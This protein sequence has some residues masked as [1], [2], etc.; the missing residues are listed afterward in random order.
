M[1]L[2]VSFRISHESPHYAR[3][4]DALVKGTRYWQY[5]TIRTSEALEDEFGPLAGR[6]LLVSTSRIAGSVK[7]PIYTATTPFRPGAIFFCSDGL[8]KHLSRIPKNLY[9]KVLK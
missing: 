2:T 5:I 9:M 6:R 7:F 3:T 8:R 4:L 1:K